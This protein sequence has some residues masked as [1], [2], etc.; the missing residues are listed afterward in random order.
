[1]E[2]LYPFSRLC[3]ELGQADG[4]DVWIFVHGDPLC[5]LCHSDVVV[6]ETVLVEVG[7]DSVPG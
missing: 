6:G 1:M 5:H 3:F 7:V 4:L 2:L